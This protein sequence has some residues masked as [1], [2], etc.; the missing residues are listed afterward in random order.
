[1][2]W[3][4]VPA[5]WLAIELFLI[6]NFAIYKPH[7]K[8]LEELVRLSGWRHAA[9]LFLIIGAAVG[10]LLLLTVHLLLS[11]VLHFY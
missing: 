11:P 9:R 7:M 6:A 5:F 2:N 8:E 3:I 10:C 4:T 1:M